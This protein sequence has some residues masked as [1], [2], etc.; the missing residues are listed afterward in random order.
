[1]FYGLLEGTSICSLTITLASSFL[2]IAYNMTE[3]YLRL[4]KL[5]YYI[6]EYRNRWVIEY[7]TCIISKQTRNINHEYVRVLVSFNHDDW[8]VTF[9]EKWYKNLIRGTKGHIFCSF[10]LFLY[11]WFSRLRLLSYLSWTG[12]PWELMYFYL[13][14]LLFCRVEVFMSYIIV[15]WC[16]FHFYFKILR[17]STFLYLPSSC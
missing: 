16:T 9:V 15:G 6:L 3:L 5:W 7:Y 11:S 14:T 12:K 17:Y 4:Y 13:F 8:S 2:Y 10:F 1:M